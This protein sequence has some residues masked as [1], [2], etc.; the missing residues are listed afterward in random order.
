MFMFQVLIRE[1]YSVHLWPGVD[2]FSLH[3]FDSG[4]RSSVL[5]C[6]MVF[7]FVCCLFLCLFCNQ[8]HRAKLKTIWFD[9]Y[10]CLHMSLNFCSWLFEFCLLLLLLLINFQY[11]YALL[12]VNFSIAIWHFVCVCVQCELPQWFASHDNCYYTE[13]CENECV[14]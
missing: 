3:V 2:C 11:I 1:L 6:Y 4:C 12:V 14:W 13:G 5:N 9:L 7:S 8:I 10:A